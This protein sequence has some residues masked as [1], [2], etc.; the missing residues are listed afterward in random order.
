MK[1]RAA[2]RILS[3]PWLAEPAMVG[4]AAAGIRRRRKQE[5]QNRKANRKANKKE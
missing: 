1:L 2:R 4:R 3:K 5:R